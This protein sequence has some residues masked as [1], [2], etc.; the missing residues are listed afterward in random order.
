MLWMYIAFVLLFSNTDAQLIYTNQSI[1]NHLLCDYSTI[2]YY[3]KH[4]HIIS[5]YIRVCI[6]IYTHTHTHIYITVIYS[7][8][9]MH[10]M[11]V[12]FTFIYCLY[13]PIDQYNNNTRP[14]YTRFIVNV[15]SQYMLPDLL[16]VRVPAHNLL[17]LHILGSRSCD[18]VM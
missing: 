6:Y 13:I 9:C 15:C 10:A 11:A 1:C 3:V 16:L 5:T 14:I 8:V 18:S 7:Y 2:T 4:T 17:L 12:M